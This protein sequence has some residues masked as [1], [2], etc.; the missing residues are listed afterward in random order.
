[1]LL[2]QRLSVTFQQKKIDNSF[3]LPINQSEQNE[4]VDQERRKNVKKG[5]IE[6]LNLHVDETKWLTSFIYF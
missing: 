1:M 2:A 4:T 3:I 5:T 6:Q